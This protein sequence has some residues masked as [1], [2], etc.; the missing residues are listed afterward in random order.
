MKKYALVMI[1][2]AMLLSPI[3]A[4]ALSIG[5]WGGSYFGIEMPIPTVGMQLTDSLAGYVG[6]RTAFESSERYQCLVK[7]DYNL[8]KLGDLQNKIGAHYQWVTDDD[9][10]IA[11]LTWGVSA[12]VLKNVSVGVDFKL[13]EQY[14]G[15][16]DL[17]TVYLTG[18]AVAIN[19]YL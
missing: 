10:V 9:A 18:T 19:F 12:M 11:G 15:G 4:Q 2:A 5:S 3:S 6:M 1:F 14:S 8:F 16:G 17:N 13:A 7:A